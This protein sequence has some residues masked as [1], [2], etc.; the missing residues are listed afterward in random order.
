ML[1]LS[2]S[3]ALGSAL[4]A[5]PFLPRGKGALILILGGIMILALSLFWSLFRPRR[6]QA[7]QQ[8]KTQP[9][10][11]AARLDSSAPGPWADAPARF[12]AALQFGA[13]WVG[14]LMVTAARAGLGRPELLTSDPLRHVL[15][16]ADCRSCRR[17]RRGSGCEYE[18]DALE[19]VMRAFEPNGRVIELVCNQ[20]RGGACTFE[21][22]P[23]ATAQ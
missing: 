20:H 17:P 7:T 9:R 13:S 6:G 4:A 2:F 3:A 16:L 11:Q 23:G 19:R 8:G 15:L 12:G 21:L 1:R 22:R 5:L 18:R 10:E 14:A